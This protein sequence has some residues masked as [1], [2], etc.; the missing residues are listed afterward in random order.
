MLASGPA[1]LKS[2]LEPIFSAIGQKTIWAGEAGAGTRLKL[3]TNN[4]LLV[5]TEGAAETVALAEGFGLDPHLFL[6]AVDGGPLD[7]PYLHIKGNA[8][9]ERDFTPSF[10]LKLAAKDAG[11][12]TE[13]AERHHVDVPLATVIRDRLAQ[14]VPEHGDEDLSATY[15]TSASSGPGAS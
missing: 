11:L 3:V 15:L 7:L 5:I 4:W 14:G 2:R 6:E 9:L 13:A 12:V 1:T 8:I 10:Q